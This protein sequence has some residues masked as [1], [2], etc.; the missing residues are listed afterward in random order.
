MQNFLTTGLFLLN[1]VN[2]IQSTPVYAA[3]PPEPPPIVVVETLEE[4][5]NRIATE[6]GVATTSLANLVTSESQWNPN[7]DNGYDRGLVQINR[8]AWPE[9]TDEQAFDPEFSLHFTA[10]K[11][12]EGKGYMWVAGNCYLF[13]QALLGK[14]PRMAEI[15]PNTPYPRV[16]GLAIFQYKS[17]HIAVITSV[18]EDGFWVREANYIPY[19]MGKRFIKFD[20]PKLLGYWSNNN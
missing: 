13:A 9:I 20:D 18:L 16:K 8:K 14:L 12:S 17:K 2:P 4:K 7:A 3:P 15:V 10:E 6:H 5:S 1:V 11:I 19:L